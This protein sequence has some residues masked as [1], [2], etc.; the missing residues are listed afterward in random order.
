MNESIFTF[1]NRE[2]SILL[3][4]SL[5]AAWILSKREFRSSILSMVKQFLHPKIFAPFLL[6]AGYVALIVMG[7]ERL[8]LWDPTLLKSTLIWGLGAGVVMF[9]NS[10]GINDGRKFFFKTITDTLK[11]IIVVEFVINFYV[12]P[13]IAELI[14]V[15]VLSFLSIM[16]VVAESQRDKKYEPVKKALRWLVSF[17]GF[18]LLSFALW[19]LFSDTG[20]FFTS[21]NARQFLLPITMTFAFMPGI[22]VLALY[23]DYEWLFIRIDHFLGRGS[24]ARVK[25]ACFRKCLLSLSRVEA[26][27]SYLVRNLTTSTGQQSV[28]A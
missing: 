24:N 12:F 26:I 11:L 19:K 16:L 23:S 14:L 21:D 2:I 7:L 17:A 3:W 18:V 10:P 22:F 28:M 9:F 8:G 5:I 6:A 27:A 15:P 4:F 20:A 25:L 13:L 1:T